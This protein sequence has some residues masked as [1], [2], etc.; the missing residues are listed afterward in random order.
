VVGPVGLQLL[1]ADEP[2][3]R[4]R[5]GQQH[6]EAGR[7]VALVDHRLAGGHGGHVALLREPVQLLVVQRLEQEQHA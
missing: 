1:A 6:V 5:A 2:G 3:Q 7:L 4:Q